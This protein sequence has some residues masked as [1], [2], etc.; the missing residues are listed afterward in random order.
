MRTSS[1]RVQVQS[2][3]AVVLC[4]NCRGGASGDECQQAAHKIASRV[5]TEMGPGHFD[6][7]QYAAQCRDH[8]DPRHLTAAHY[9]KEVDCVLNANSD[10]AVIDCMKRTKVSEATVMLKSIGD[11]V[12]SI[13]RS[14]H[15][16]P[17]GNAASTAS[18]DLC[19]LSRREVK[20]DWSADLWRGLHIAFMDAPDKFDNPQY[21]VTYVGEA[22]EFHA[23]AVGDTDCDGSAAT[24][25]L[26]GRLVDGDLKTTWQ[27]PSIGAL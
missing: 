6:E 9:R 16:I 10:E 1:V 8:T 21:L 14:S 2:A 4:A 3:L 19:A 7:A 15:G 27:L 11:A 26:D 18:R 20:P 24:W 5:S 17:V 25:Q 22:S 23:E 12:K 13:A